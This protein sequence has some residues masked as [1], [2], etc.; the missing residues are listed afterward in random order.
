MTKA[1]VAE[2]NVK[3]VKTTHKRK[4]EVVVEPAQPAQVNEQ[5]VKVVKR[6]K[7]TKTPKKTKKTDAP[8]EV[9]AP[10][11]EA[12]PEAP[13]PV[14][15][16]AAV[17]SPLTFMKMPG[18][19][20]LSSVAQIEK[21]S[22]QCYEELMRISNNYLTNVVTKAMI[23]T[24]HSRKTTVG[25]DEVLHALE[26]YGVRYYGGGDVAPEYFSVNK[27]QKKGKNPMKLKSRLRYYG[28]HSHQLYLARKPLVRRIKHIANEVREEYRF[29]PR[30]IDIIQVVLERVLVQILMS[31]YRVTQNRDSKTVQLKDI[32]VVMEIR[33]MTADRDALLNV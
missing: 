33:A 6:R 5:E 31:A 9:P 22:K 28:E 25:H 16:E 30:A 26:L 12:T 14:V 32:R 18:I 7:T 11:Q 19:K 29:S 13:A 17:E 24:E 20:R 15:A 3:P 2:S 21:I 1:V 4:R 10:V 23:L 8:E 27:M